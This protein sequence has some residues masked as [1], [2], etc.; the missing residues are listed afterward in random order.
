MTKDDG[1]M[2]SGDWRG[3]SSTTPL[4]SVAP[5]RP[6]F[7]RA[8]ELHLRARPASHREECARARQILEAGRDAMSGQMAA[9]REGRAVQTTELVEIVD[10][11]TASLMRDPVALPSITRLRQ[12]DEYTFT[13]SVAVCGWM[14]A[15]AQ[16]LNF[17]PEDIRDAGLAGLLHDIG[18]AVLPAYLLLPHAGMTPEDKAAIREHPARGYAMLQGVPDMSELVLEV[19][20]D[21]HERPDGRGFP[22]GKSGDAVGRNARIAAICNFYDKVTSPP[23]G[24]PK[25]SSSQAIDHMRDHPGEFDTGLVRA[26]GRVVGTFLPGALVRLRSDR[27]G[28]VLDETERDPLHPMV[29][30]FRYASGGTIPWLRISTKTDPIIGIERPETWRFD[31]WPTLRTQLLELSE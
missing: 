9:A 6:V 16:E 7:G 30:V 12:Q 11:V 21:H 2:L 4:R 26:F 24:Q 25:W 10:G 31:D 29:A 18:K 15:M 3:P 1:A 14:V 5:K 22:A 19:V 17:A 8:R 13:H 27:L 20:R 28:V 23:P